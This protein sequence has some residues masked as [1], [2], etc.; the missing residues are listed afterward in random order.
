M[1]LSMSPEDL[2]KELDRQ[3]ELNSDQ[4]VM[5][6]SL[7]TGIDRALRVESDV[8]A[9]NAILREI[10]TKVL[11]DTETRDF[12]TSADWWINRVNGKLR[13]GRFKHER[14]PSHSS[15]VPE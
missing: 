7:Q 3:R 9:E 13:V 11:K 1:R 6:N 14:C 2:A 4:C 12:P 10:L 8:L 5:I 15:A